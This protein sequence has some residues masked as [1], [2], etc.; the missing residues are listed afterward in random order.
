[1]NLTYQQRLAEQRAQKIQT[2]R[3]PSSGQQR[4]N[5]HDKQHSYVSGKPTAVAEQVE[6]S[7]VQAR[8][9]LSIKNAANVIKRKSSYAQNTL[10]L[11]VNVNRQKEV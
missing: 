9:I 5:P 2:Q 8:S 6:Q 10:D 4:P 1:M 7:F 11:R 3:D